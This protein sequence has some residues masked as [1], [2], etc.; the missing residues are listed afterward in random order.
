M[1]YFEGLTNE[2]E[3]K[4]RYKELAKTHHPDRGGCVETM[5]RI[6]SQYEN[7]MKGFYQAAGKSISEIDELF[8]QDYLMR[9]KLNLILAL[10]GLII[11]ICGN[12]LWVTGETKPHKDVL[13]SCGFFWASKKEAWYYRS[14]QFK[15]CGNRS[16]RTL[17]EI[18]YKHGSLNIT[19]KQR[20]AIA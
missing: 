8:E 7:C 17:D 11:E 20:Y 12:W 9:Q 15:S 18:R 14:E 16:S 4:Q 13:K 10:E 6:N 3:V 2:I 5:K 19:G 1:K